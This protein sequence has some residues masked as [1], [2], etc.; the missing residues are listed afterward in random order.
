M[1]NPSGVMHTCHACS[2]EA[3][4]GDVDGKSSDKA[5]LCL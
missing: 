2:Q 4:L 5:R 1:H 3:D